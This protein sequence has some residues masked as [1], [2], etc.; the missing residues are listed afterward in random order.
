MAESTSVQIF[1]GLAPIFAALLTFIL[2][3]TLGEWVRRNRLRSH[4]L[5]SLIAEL[6]QNREHQ[7]SSIYIELDDEALR[8]FRRLGFL[9]ELDSDMKEDLMRLY[10]LIHLKNSLLTYYRDVGVRLLATEYEASQHP[11]KR[12]KDLLDILDLIKDAKC[13]IDKKIE[14]VLPK[15]KG[16]LEDP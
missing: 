10:S 12:E 6:E 3:Q 11:T 15:L 4:G 1:L 13:K 5:E 9:F 16:L 8:R 2:L 7:K 14:V